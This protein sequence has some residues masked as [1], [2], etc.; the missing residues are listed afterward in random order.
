M[1]RPLTAEA[2]GK[3]LDRLDADRERAGAIYEDLRRT[4][5]RF[6][7]WR[8]APSPEDHTDETLDRVARKLAESVEIRNV[9][10][11]C[12]EVA[13]LVW[14]E[15]LKSPDSRQ[16]PIRTDMIDGDSAKSGE[17]PQ[18][19]ARLRCLDDCLGVLQPDA[20]D[21]IL[22]YYGDG[23]GSRIARRKALAERLGLQREVLANRAQRV[24]NRLETCVSGCLSES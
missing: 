20:R 5:I 23:D 24:R 12:Y 1:A 2:F 7:Q 14:L 4:M 21:L 17:D 9:R 15:T 13:R 8:S 11:Y 6:F 18:M 16:V 10:G 19:E 22:G 3:L